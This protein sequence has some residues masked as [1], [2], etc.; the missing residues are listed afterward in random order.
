MAV[1]YFI[2]AK[3]GEYQKDG[4]TKTQW[5]D[6]G[7]VIETQKGFMIKMN[8]IP[9]GWDGVAFLSDPQQK[10][11]GNRGNSARARPAPKDGDMDDD[12]PF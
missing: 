3:G 6:I 9:V 7:V 1:R 8:S 5:L 4:E 10:P 11:Q 2:K 12:V